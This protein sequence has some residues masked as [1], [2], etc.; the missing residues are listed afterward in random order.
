MINDNISRDEKSMKQVYKERAEKFYEL[1]QSGETEEDI[2]SA[3]FLT[4]SQV[5]KIIG[6]YESRLLKSKTPKT[7]SRRKPSK[8]M[9]AAEHRAKEFRELKLKGVTLEDIGTT[10]GITRQRVDQLIKRYERRYNLPSSTT[11]GKQLAR[12]AKQADKKEYGTQKK[13]DRQFQGKHVVETIQLDA[14]LV[15]RFLQA[16]AYRRLSYRFYGRHR[17]RKDGTYFPGNKNPTCVEFGT[18]ENGSHI[19]YKLHHWVL[20][21]YG[22]EVPE[23]MD[24]HHVDSDITNNMRENLQVLSGAEH[25]R[26]TMSEQWERRTLLKPKMEQTTFD[27]E[28]LTN[29]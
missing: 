29:L 22:I 23:G 5:K 1:K 25:M 24:C 15:G 2:A 27:D 3:Y 16:L 26:I 20:R 19:R 12:S 18:Q 4:V 9:L 8:S 7:V 28:F 11:T 10:Y 17:K 14:G 6:G 13:L 21:Q